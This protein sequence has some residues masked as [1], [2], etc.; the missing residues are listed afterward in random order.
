MAPLREAAAT[1]AAGRVRG[2]LPLY[3]QGTSS[4]GFNCISA[5]T[6]YTRYGDWFPLLCAVIAVMCLIADRVV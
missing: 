3:V 5:Q 4:T 2:T 6:V 1:A